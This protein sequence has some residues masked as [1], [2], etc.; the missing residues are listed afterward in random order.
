MRR[1]ALLHTTPRTCLPCVAYC[2][3][4]HREPDIVHKTYAPGRLI[5]PC[6]PR[7]LSCIV[8]NVVLHGAWHG[9][10]SCC[11]L[12]NVLFALASFLGRPAWR[13]DMSRLPPGA[14]LAR[15]GQ[16][17]IRA[18]GARTRGPRDGPGTPWAQPLRTPGGRH[19]V[20]SKHAFDGLGIHVNR[21]CLQAV[22]DF[23]LRWCKCLQ[24]TNDEKR[25][26]C[27]LGACDSCGRSSGRPL[28]WETA[29]SLWKRKRG[30]KQLPVTRT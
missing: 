3:G 9:M 15:G 14:Q 11:S 26:R 19:A 10:T 13:G 8:I 22:G 27:L 18:R 20:S 30:R 16:G 1:A 24:L 12:Q 7:I 23:G 29:C 4:R 21:L 28:A 17:K 5:I 6:L 2:C 25:L